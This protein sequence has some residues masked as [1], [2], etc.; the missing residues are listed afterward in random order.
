MGPADC[1]KR[2]F[3]NP[4]L[5]NEPLR[6]AAA[7]AKGRNPFTNPPHEAYEPW[8]G[9]AN[10]T[11]LAKPLAREPKAGGANLGELIFTVPQ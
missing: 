8:P 5:Q 1:L 3:A 4:N 2:T 10:P 6:T 9:F 11:R 7:F